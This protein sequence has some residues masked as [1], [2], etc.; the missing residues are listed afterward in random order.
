M[1]IIE[2]VSFININS[3]IKLRAKALLCGC[4]AKLFFIAA[5]GGALRAVLLAAVLP[6]VYLLVRPP[7]SEA[8]AALFKK[9]LIAAPV[10]FGIYLLRIT[11]CIIAAALRLGEQA[12]FFTRADGGTPKF[13]QLFSFFMPRRAAAAFSLYSKL[14]LYR[15]AWLALFLL[16]G[17]LVLEGAALNFCR[18]SMPAAAL[19]VLVCGSA[20]LSAVGLIFFT[21][22]CAR[23][24]TAAFY[25]ING[26]PPSK[27]I[28]KSAL[29]CD[30]AIFD[31]LKLR[32]SLAGWY[33]LCLTGIGA[34]YALPYIKLANAVF[35]LNIH[36]NAK[37]PGEEPPHYSPREKIIIDNK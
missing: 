7:L 21:A 30:G 11:I 12:A 35:A 26:A 23:Y 14:L 13:G 25:T 4:N 31:F 5:L 6:G 32:T 19:A 2:S 37:S 18:G 27:A 1:F 8:L 29:V 36:K 3:Y 28:K 22:S 24:C 10:L 15:A 9:P 17:T 16:P 34:F 20:L 33:A